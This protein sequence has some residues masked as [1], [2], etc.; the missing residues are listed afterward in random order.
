MAQEPE[1]DDAATTEEKIAEMNQWGAGEVVDHIERDGV[2]RGT[3]WQ[4]AETEMFVVWQHNQAGEPLDM[5]VMFEQ[6]PGDW[7]HYI[8]FQE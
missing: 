1:A 4:P 5:V 8:D 6:E 3:M 7:S 2:I